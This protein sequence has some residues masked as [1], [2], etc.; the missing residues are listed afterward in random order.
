MWNIFFRKNG[1][2]VVKHKFILFYSRLHLVPIG[3]LHSRV[4]TALSHIT[5]YVVSH[6]KRY[7]VLL[8]IK[9]R[10]IGSSH[11]LCGMSDYKLL[12]QPSLPS[13]KQF[14]S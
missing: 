3:I 6:I 14:I 1:K 7:V 8:G 13:S 10:E 11:L 2:K 4:T 12:S 5:R 9:D